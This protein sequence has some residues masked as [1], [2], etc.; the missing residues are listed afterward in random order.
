M[1]VKQ[2]IEDARTKR[3]KDE[4]L[5]LIAEYLQYWDCDIDAFEESVKDFQWPADPQ[6]EEKWKAITEKVFYRLAHDPQ[7]KIKVPFI[8]KLAMIRFALLDHNI[9]CEY[10]GT[11]FLWMIRLKQNFEVSFES[12]VRLNPITG[13]WRQI[14]A[15]SHLLR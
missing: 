2:F 6:N 7:F 8:V 13:L 9:Q 10:S 14:E 12:S 1:Y 15:V 3:S 4:L 11:E 5:S